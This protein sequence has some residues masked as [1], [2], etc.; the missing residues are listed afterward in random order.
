[1]TTHRRRTA[2]AQVRLRSILTNL[3]AFTGG[4]EIADQPWRKEDRHKEAED[5]GGHYLNHYF[6]NIL[7]SSPLSRRSET[8]HKRCALEDLTRTT[9]FN[10]REDQSSTRG[11][12]VWR[13]SSMCQM[14]SSI[15]RLTIVFIPRSDAAL[16]IASP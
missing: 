16:A 4:G 7:S 15:S 12:G 2:L 3:L 8:S 6:N 5:A 13:T 10:S 14:A 9:S 1:Q 11:G